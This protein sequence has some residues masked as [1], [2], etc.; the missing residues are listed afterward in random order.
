MK[1]FSDYYGKTL[2]FI[3]PSIWK[4]KFELRD[5]NNVV[6]TLVYPKFF[7]RKAE[8]KIFDIKWEFYEPQWWKRLIEIR[9]MGKELPIA[10]YKPPTFKQKGK[11]ELP[12][13]ESV[14][15]CNN[16]FRTAFEIQDRYEKRLVLF[17]NKFS[18]RTN[19][20]IHVEKRSEIMD[21]YPWILLL[22]VYV[23]INKK[24][25]RSS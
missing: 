21:K 24:R 19:T 22:I 25:Q 6:G 13:G 16:F 12:H 18:I 2:L 11:L 14:F 15:L 23:E 1:T 4:R 9:E 3:Q 20:E 8:V 7:S 10:S 5:G 17:E